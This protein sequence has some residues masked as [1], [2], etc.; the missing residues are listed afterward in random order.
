MET[1]GSNRLVQAYATYLE[2]TQGVTLRQYE[3]EDKYADP[4]MVRFIRQTLKEVWPRGMPPL[5]QAG[6]DPEMMWH[7]AEAVVDGYQA[8]PP[9]EGI[10]GG[11]P[12]REGSN[13]SQNH[14]DAEVG[15]DSTLEIAMDHYPSACQKRG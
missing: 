10:V 6:G 4:E 3:T 2:E 15:C 11:L 14:K 13:Q 7:E 8:N 9:E 1:L 12:T 5:P